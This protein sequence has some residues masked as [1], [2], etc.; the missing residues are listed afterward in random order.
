VDG[1]LGKVQAVLDS[2]GMTRFI[3]IVAVFAL[4]IGLY[5]NYQQNRYTHCLASYNNRA[6]AVSTQRSE[7]LRSSTDAVDKFLQAI[8]HSGALPAA[9]RADAIRNAF[10]T[11]LKARATADE[12]RK[13]NPL[14]EPPSETC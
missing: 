5:A 12:Q 13:L 7:A 9:Q 2:R 1:A 3:Q 6:S 14:P 8:A 4:F 10:E 11:Y